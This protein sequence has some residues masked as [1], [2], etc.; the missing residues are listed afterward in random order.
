MSKADINSFNTDELIEYVKRMPV[1]LPLGTFKKS[2]EEVLLQIAKHFIQSFETRRDMDEAQ[3]DI[4]FEREAILK[5]W[6][7]KAKALLNQTREDYFSWHNTLD[8]E[9]RR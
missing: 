9:P 7:T 1:F 4:E 8:K 5:A 2:K 3:R 6:K